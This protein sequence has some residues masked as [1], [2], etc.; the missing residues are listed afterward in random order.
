MFVYIT[1]MERSPDTWFFYVILDNSSNCEMET[2]GILHWGIYNITV[3]RNF[4]DTTKTKRYTDNPNTCDT[5]NFSKAYLKQSYEAYLL[6]FTWLMERVNSLPRMIDEIIVQY[7]ND[8]FM[9][10][11]LQSH[12]EPNDGSWKLLHRCRISL[13]CHIPH[14]KM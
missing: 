7:S 11:V 2:Y 12:F 9:D 5:G 3:L 14:Q 8:M 10:L 4:Y 6:H 1:I 13:F